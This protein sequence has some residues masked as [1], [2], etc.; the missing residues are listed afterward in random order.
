[1]LPTEHKRGRE[2]EKLKEEKLTRIGSEGD[3][4]E[5]RTVSVVLFSEN[6][7][8]PVTTC[9]WSFLSECVK[10]VNNFGPSQLIQHSES[11]A[12]LTTGFTF[13][14]GTNFLATAG[15]SSK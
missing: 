15:F 12:V 14:R 11:S 9:C 13:P 7:L 2:Q 10:H 6:V 8:F 3:D 4:K 5:E 1:M